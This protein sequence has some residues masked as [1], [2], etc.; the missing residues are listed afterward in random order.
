MVDRNHGERRAEKR[1]NESVPIKLFSV[2]KYDA[3]A[4]TKNISASGAYCSLSTKIPEMTK[5][6]IKLSIP[7][8][9]NL[10]SKRIDCQGVVV[11]TEN[12]EKNENYN[13]AIYFNDIT[14]CDK[15]YIRKYVNYHLNEE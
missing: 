8:V 5:L 15:E 9:G 3:I 7:N 4:E 6:Q 14:E 13:I 12:D 11:R 1:V 2:E 10:S